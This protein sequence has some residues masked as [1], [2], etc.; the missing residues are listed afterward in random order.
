[1]KFEKNVPIPKARRGRWAYMLEMEVGDSCFLEEY[2]EYEKARNALYHYA[3][4][5]GWKTMSRKEPD[6]SGW[7]LWRLT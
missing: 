3:K 6:G 5:N 2:S 4:K 1:M 7:R